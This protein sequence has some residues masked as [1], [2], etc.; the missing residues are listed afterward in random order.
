MLANILFA[1]GLEKYL[2]QLYID[3][4]YD[5]LVENADSILNIDPNEPSVNLFK[6]RVL[7]DQE[8]YLD[9]KPYILKAIENDKD[10]S[11]KKA[12]GLFYL[13]QIENACGNREKSK[14]CLIDCIK[15]NATQNVS[16]ASRK[17]AMLIGLD[18]FYDDWSQVETEHFIFLF[19]PNSIVNNR[20]KFIE[21]REESFKNI[22]GFFKSKVPRKIA[23]IVW[24]GDGDA[25]K[26]GIKQ[27]G[28]SKPELCCIHSRAKQSIGHEMTHVISHYITIK[29]VKTRFIN[30]GIAVAFD[31][32]GVDNK[33]TIAKE[34]K[35]KEGFT[36]KIL[37]K[38]AWN[39]PNKYPE[40]VYYSFA[41]E[42][43]KRLIAKGGADKFLKLA[44]NQTYDYA[45]TIYGDQLLVI[46]ND[47]EKEIN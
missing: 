45:K 41:G 38:E 2:G 11:Y 19:Q 27:L 44:A 47:L 37:I 7:V 28:F 43:V 42:F 10:K 15:M 16:N 5:L 24:N 26:V 32:N 13:A 22:D 3:K 18:E 8:N 17:Y 33:I 20:R 6:G 14:L 25:R 9:G 12:W 1:Q 4:K 46:I 31:Q 21:I 23:F 29:P 34:S 40:W 39:I 36:D 35:S 30:E